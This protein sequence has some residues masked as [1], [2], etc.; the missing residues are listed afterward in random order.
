MGGHVRRHR[1]PP[2]RPADLR[3]PAR[4]LLPDEAR[5]G[6]PAAEADTADAEFW[7]AVEQ[8]DLESLADWLEIDGGSLGAVLP[9]L[10]A[11]R[12]GA[13]SSPPWTPGATGPSGGRCECPRCRC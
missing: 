7:S 1:C 4:A 5:T 10:S 11:W 13:V 6:A 12:A 3:V 8:E 2:C 9:A